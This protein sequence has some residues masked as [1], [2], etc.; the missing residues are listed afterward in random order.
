MPQTTRQIIGLEKAIVS[1]RN[2]AT[3][4]FHVV[5]Q[6]QVSHI[7]GASSVSLAGYVSREVF[8][9]GK[10]FVMLET[11]SINALPATGRIEDLPTWFVQQ[12]LGVSGHDYA[13]AMPV[14]AN[15]DG[16]AEHATGTG[17]EEI[18]A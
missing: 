13:G 6:Y 14:Y 16:V 17:D 8:E 5:K 2:G 10:E 1:R 18:A 11:L 3:A 9:D 15:P 12:L 7:S 4:S